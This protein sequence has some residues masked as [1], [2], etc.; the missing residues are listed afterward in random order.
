MI[1][2]EYQT[3][4]TKSIE[5]AVSRGIQVLK[6]RPPQRGSEW[7]RQHFKLERGQEFIPRPSQVAV[8]DLG[9]DRDVKEVVRV[10]P[11]RTGGTKELIA[12]A[13]GNMDMFHSDSGLWLPSD[14]PAQNFSKREIKPL[15][16]SCK[17]LQKKHAAAG[18]GKSD[19][20]LDMKVLSTCYLQILGGQSETNYRSV[21]LGFVGVDELSSF[22]SNIEGM[23]S[24]GALLRRRLQDALYPKFLPSSTPGIEGKCQISA[25]AEEAHVWLEYHI[26]CP[27]CGQLQAPQW[28]GQDAAYGIKFGEGKG[29]S[30]TRRAEQALYICIDCQGAFYYADS[31]AN[32][33][34]SR[35]QTLDGQI[36]LD[37][38]SKFTDEHG[39][40]EPF[41]Q[42]AMRNNGI[43][44]HNISWAE[45]GL[46]WFAANKALQSGET[47]PLREF[48]TQY[49]AELW[50]ELADSLVDTDSVSQE[51][52]PADG[53]IPADVQVITAW[54]DVQKDRIE[55]QTKGWGFG[56]ES[57]GLDYTVIFGD[58]TG[59]EIWEKVAKVFDREFITEQGEV[60]KILLCGVDHGGHW[61]EKVEQFCYHYDPFRCIPTKGDAGEGKPVARFPRKRN[62]KKVFLTMISTFPAKDTVYQRLRLEQTGPG[63]MHYPKP[64]AERYTDYD[65]QFY[66]GLTA[67]RKLKAGNRIKWVL[68]SGR[69]N[70]PLDTETGNLC[71]IRVCQ[72]HMGITLDDYTQ[73]EPAE[74]EES[75]AEILARRDEPHA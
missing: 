17:P 43:I 73:P 13:F 67:E 19:D 12:S 10:K 25:L 64:Q 47:G 74:V 45:A 53:T 9:C 56:E 20:T 46:Q 22:E 70:E 40:I 60:L 6:R 44:S 33:H 61:A 68:P 41:K 39:E 27:H 57:W 26:A 59:G 15:L 1:T 51:D 31:Q 42:V 11:A 55:I 5:R 28:G 32:M 2:P 30:A 8:L 63:Y 65:K 54:G 49:L 14:K 71:L 69:R 58:P 52:Y 23:G 75:L 7:A 62:A 37:E 66:R 18:G 72:S 24:P 38:N 50:T 4:Q 34:L 35:W 21:T 29:L 48:N 3:T 36:W 16:R